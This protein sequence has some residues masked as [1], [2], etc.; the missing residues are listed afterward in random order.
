MINL[1]F[2][3]SWRSWIP[4]PLANKKLRRRMRRPWSTFKTKS[5]DLMTT[6][7][8]W[9]R[10]WKMETRRSRETTTCIWIKRTKEISKPHNSWGSSALDLSQSMFAYPLVSLRLDS[11]K[12][13]LM[14]VPNHGKLNP[15]FRKINEVHSH[16]AKVITLRASNLDQLIEGIGLKSNARF[17]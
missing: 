2:Y 5:T 3:E 14:M 13:I 1:I 15:I 7:K 16:I 9:K 4:S 8:S 10:S 6:W 17:P 12:R 11:Q